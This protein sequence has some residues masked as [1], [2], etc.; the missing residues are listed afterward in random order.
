LPIY[1]CIVVRNSLVIVIS[2]FAKNVDANKNIL[3]FAKKNIIHI[4]VH[5]VFLLT[6]NKTRMKNGYNNT[7][8]I[9][10]TT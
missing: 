9:A 7:K 6:T 10:L 2:S 1:G 5:N 4:V 8:D 3:S